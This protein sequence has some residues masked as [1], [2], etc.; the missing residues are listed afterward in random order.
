MN[1]E[2][3]L[4]SYSIDDLLIKYR[5]LNKFYK[6]IIASHCLEFDQQRQI[7]DFYNAFNDYECFEKVIL[8][9]L[10][11]AEREK[12]QFIASLLHNEI[13]KNCEI[14]LNN[15]ELFD[16]ID[17]IKVCSNRP[18]DIHYK[19][20]VQGKYTTEKWKELY[21]IRK[22]ID[23]VGYCDHYSEEHLKSL[24]KDEEKMMKLYEIEQD[25]LALLYKEERKSKDYESK[26][27]ENCFI[28]IFN[29]N[30][31]FLKSVSYY[32]P[33][34][35][36]KNENSN[37]PNDELKQEMYFDMEIVSK[38]HKECNGIQFETLTEIEL[39]S[40]LNLLPKNKVFNYEEEEKTRMCILVGGLYNHLKSL[41][42]TNAMHWRKEMLMLLEI[43]KEKY[44]DKKYR[45]HKD[46]SASDDD[47]EFAQ[48]ISQVLPNIL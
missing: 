21:N 42:V 24:E 39:Y 47:V 27:I 9:F 28:K 15:S 6:E 43:D 41:K 16:S 37:T 23:N 18:N 13:N 46:A 8:H 11:I 17:T 14:Y 10:R 1:I 38:V 12:A 44:Y 3:T 40:I 22:S 30:N 35:A 48:R 32:F 20:K 7:T 33:L 2:N 26:Y 25:K 31:I 5:M 36:E 34:K 4:A 29:L 19:I 45:K